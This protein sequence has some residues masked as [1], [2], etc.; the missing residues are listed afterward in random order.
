MLEPYNPTWYE[1]PIRMNSPQALGDLARST[2]VWICASETL[3]SC[4]PYKDML[5]REPCIS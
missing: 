3:G 5:D 2:D 1:D 4:F